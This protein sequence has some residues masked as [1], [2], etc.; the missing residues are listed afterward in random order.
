MALHET[1]RVMFSRDIL[2]GCD[3]ELFFEK[4][5]KVI[6]SEKVIP[7]KMPSYLDR[8]N[9]AYNSTNMGIVQDGVQVELNPRPDWCRAHVGNELAII[10]KT[11]KDHLAKM[12]DVHISFNGVVD[13]DPAELAALSEKSRTLGCAPSKNVY[14]KGAS[15]SV[16]N[17]YT[18]RSAGGHLHLGLPE[19][20]KKYPEG[21]AVILDIL[22]GNTSVLIDR[23]PNAAERRKV[24]GRAGEFRTPKH[25]FEYRT[26]SNFWL[27]SYPL[28]SFVMGLAR[29]SVDVLRS[30]VFQEDTPVVRPGVYIEKPSVKLWDTEAKL[31]EYVDVGAVREA[32]NT[33]NLELAK[34]NYQGV[35]RFIEN[36]VPL[37]DSGLDHTKLVN[38]DYFIQMID[39]KGLEYWF[40]DD[41]IV[42]WTEKY[43]EG[44]DRGWETFLTNIVGMKRNVSVNKTKTLKLNT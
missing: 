34:Q 2:F 8:Y 36:H 3:P 1:E 39:E 35:R 19:Y 9:P 40:P 42:H 44:H 24:Y 12:D 29:L 10:F 22:L 33:N 32:I 14:D 43:T 41:P 37:M 4:G 17:T 26:L 25:G 11:L 21:L 23:D 15:V 7:E 16:S 6:G 20:M 30:K 5:G 38:F 13:V 18:K 27:R 31:R 28:M